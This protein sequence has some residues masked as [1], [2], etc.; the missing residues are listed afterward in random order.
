[1]YNGEILYKSNVILIIKFNFY[2]IEQIKL[3]I[4]CYLYLLFFRHFIEKVVRTAQRN[5]I[6]WQLYCYFSKMCYTK[7]VSL[8]KKANIGRTNKNTILR[9]ESLFLQ[10]PRME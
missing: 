7:D 2:A 6:I 4:L 9:K 1:M 8:C 10:M 5:E 3:T